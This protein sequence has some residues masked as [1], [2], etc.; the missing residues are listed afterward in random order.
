[1]APDRRTQVILL[2]VLVA[3]GIVAY[4]V[5]Y[6]SG[7]TMP[8]SN[9]TA[10]GRATVAP[11]TAPSVQTPDVRL[12]ELESERPKPGNNGRNLFQFKPKAAPPTPPPKLPQ[13]PQAP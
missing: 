11:N 9:G 12:P 2:V 8:T 3:L 13:A 1:M 10:A 4:R 7:E 6:P 5:L